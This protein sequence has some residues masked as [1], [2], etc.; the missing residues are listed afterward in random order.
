MTDTASPSPPAGEILHSC[1]RFHVRRDGRFLVTELHAPHRVLSTSEHRGGQQDRLRFLANHQSCE[2]SGDEE[3]LEAIIRLGTVAYHRQTCSEAGL[4]PER[5]ALMSTAA[6]MAYAV[7]R[8][9]EFEDLRADAVVTAGVS[10]N[11]A[12]AGDPAQWLET[13]DGWRKVPACAGTINTMLLLNCPVTDSAQ[14]RAIV[15]LTEAKSAALAELAVPSLYSPTIATGTGTDQ[16]CV[17]AP[18]VPERKPK[19]STSPHVKLGELIGIAVRDA[20]KEALRWQNGLEPS[21]TRELFHAL[22]RFGLTEQLALQRLADLL[23]ERHYALL[24]KNRKAVF[25][26][27]G[28]AAAAYGIAAVLDRIEFGTLPR[29]LAH[30]ALRQQAACLACSLAARPREWTRFRD[31]L[32]EAIDDPIELVLA[33]I[34]AGWKSKWN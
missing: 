2:G 6:S 26:D 4:D 30:E 9:A 3:R 7:H 22:G 25:F 21:F 12:R 5:T 8:W 10:G 28:A 1:P 32:P 23:P 31:E 27:P 13:D 34:A 17:A 14:A 18:L 19:T 16:F 24:A 29:G 33:A 20:V 11:A 15:T